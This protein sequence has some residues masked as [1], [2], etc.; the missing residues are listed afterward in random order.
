MKQIIDDFYRIILGIP[1]EESVPKVAKVIST[2]VLVGV[3]VILFIA[4]S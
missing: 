2:I 4:K 1:P 3:L